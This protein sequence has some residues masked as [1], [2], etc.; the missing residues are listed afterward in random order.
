MKSGVS[1]PVMDNSEKK[2]PVWNLLSHASHI[3]PGPFFSRNVIREI[4][5][6]ESTRGR[7]Q[8]F[9]SFFRSP[10]ISGAVA[11]ATI[12][13]AS[14]FFLEVSNQSPSDNPVAA[15]GLD[16]GFDP[17]TELEAVEYL[18]QLMAVTDPAQLSDEAFA[19]LFF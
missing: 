10:F 5:Q 7:L 2:D 6:M 16:S 14:I 12:A 4:R 3:E 8:T 13:I 19:D 1:S 18:G 11:V 17:A 9:L 15:T